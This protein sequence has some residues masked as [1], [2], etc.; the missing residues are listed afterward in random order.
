M[1][2]SLQWQQEL[3]GAVRV[4][5]HQHVHLLRGGRKEA[6]RSQQ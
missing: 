5:S 4:Q 6:C 2:L 3:T 1:E